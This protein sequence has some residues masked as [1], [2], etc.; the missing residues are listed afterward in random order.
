[1]MVQQLLVEGRDPKSITNRLIN[2]AVRG[3][4]VIGRDWFV[5]VLRSESGMVRCL[6]APSGTS[7]PQ[8]GSPSQPSNQSG[9]ARTTARCCFCGLERA[10]VVV[11]VVLDHSG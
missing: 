8:R 10:A 3:R 4:Q 9:A 1:M 6:F 2:E 7:T 5:A 11:S